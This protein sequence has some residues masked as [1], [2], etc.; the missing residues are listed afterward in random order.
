MSMYIYIYIYIIYIYHIHYLD[1]A[2]SYRNLPPT[3]VETSKAQ[4]QRPVSTLQQK[5]TKPTEKPWE[6]MRNTWKKT[7]EKKEN[8]GNAW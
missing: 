8:M 3:S 7:H 2:Q 5:H 6:H 1:M 4:L